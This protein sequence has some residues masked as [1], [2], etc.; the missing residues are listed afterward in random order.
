V[1]S[2]EGGER[3][4]PAFG[5][6]RL[7][8]R[9]GVFV[10]VA[11]LVLLPQ[12][13]SALT[14]YT[15]NTTADSGSGSLRE[16]FA[17]A[18]TDN[19]D[20]EIL[21]PGGT[22]TVGTDTGVPLP[23]PGEAGFELTVVGNGT[24]LVAD[25]ALAVGTG[26][27]VSAGEVVASGL[28]IRDFPGHG[29]RLEGTVARAEIGLSGC[30]AGAEIVIA[31]NSFNGVLIDGLADVTVQCAVITRN[32]DDGIA[33]VN[34]ANNVMIRDNP[35]IFENNTNGVK[36]GRDAN[37]VVVRDNPAIEANGQ[38]GVLI[39]DGATNNLL[40][41][42]NGLRNNRRG[43]IQIETPDSFGNVVTDNTEIRDN[44]FVGIGIS[45]GARDNLIYGND[46]IQE[47]SAGEEQ[48]VGIDL[49]G[50]APDNVILAN[51]SIEGHPSAGIRVDGA[52]RTQ[53]GR[54]G[55]ANQVRLN[56]LGIWILGTSTDIEI[57]GNLV[58]D[59]LFDGVRLTGEATGA[60]L[61]NNTVQFQ[62]T[63]LP[64]TFGQFGS[65]TGVRIRG[66]VDDAQLTDNDITHQRPGF[67]R[68][69]CGG[70]VR[71]RGCRAGQYD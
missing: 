13:A 59:N 64:F 56:N 62:D 24:V 11:A 33:A 37:N 44:R 16:A 31:D 7:I 68:P 71:R 3:K 61:R 42:A 54:L 28:E 43:G 67:D 21:A 14:T 60:R 58:E 29:V 26:M 45:D 55:Q 12:A 69:D 63:S 20:S 2:V 46:L 25:A 52:L 48:N 38:A 9:C 66:N 10:G 57:V 19:D 65:S 22:I 51:E 50:A 5:A 4:S 34:G 15:V 40:G 39:T 49:T 6:A 18:A 47:T 36:I 8:K 23:D 53:I 35:A 1:R 17:L 70:S 41:P 32:G 27:V 30:P